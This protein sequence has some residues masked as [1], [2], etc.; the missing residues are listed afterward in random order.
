M[1]QPAIQLTLVRPDDEH[2][3]SRDNKV[4]NRSEL[5][6]NWRLTFK[7]VG[8]DMEVIVMKWTPNLSQSRK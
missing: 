6:T 4:H 7:F 2:L 5:L 1:F 8:K 3:H